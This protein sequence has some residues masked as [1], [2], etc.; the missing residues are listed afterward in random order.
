[1]LVYMIQTVDFLFDKT[2]EFE[3][4]VDLSSA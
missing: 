1:M 4:D 3:P 2:V